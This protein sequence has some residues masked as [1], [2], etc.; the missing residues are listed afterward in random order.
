MSRNLVTSDTAP[1][2]K[3]STVWAEG[4]P[5]QVRA[6]AGHP[7]RR[8]LLRGTRLQ[9]VSFLVSV[10]LFSLPLIYIA[11]Q[12]VRPYTAFL[13]N[14]TG[15]PRSFTLA[16]I[17]AAWEQGGFA[18]QF[19]NGALFAGIPDIATLILGV[20][21]AFPISRAYVRFSGAL[22]ALFVFGPFLP[23][24]IIP[25]FI[26]AK[27]LHMYD[28][29]LGYILLVSL[30]G[31][32]GFFFFVGY[33]KGIPRELDEAAALDGCGY[34]RFIFRI[35]IPQMR[36]P[37]AT[38]GIVGFV[39]GWNNFIL[40]LVMLPDSGLWPVTRGL[41]SYFGEY[42]ESLPA[43]AAATLIV[44]VPIIVVY[45]IFQRNI[46]EGVSGGARGFGG[47]AATGVRAAASKA[48]QPS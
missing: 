7:W 46:L 42:T 35:L 19:L 44:A 9:V 37:L 47:T 30:N 15:I 1:Q 11:V 20:F 3:H 17:T 32:A 18:H 48:D 21:L 33:I 14:P 31:G 16:N 26:E 24:G 41:Y 23:V 34:I 25:L 43:V 2:T 13:Q 29:F 10:G 45:A 4:T 5:P 38:F 6:P 8:R 27:S 28:N 36:A 22:Y 40:P 39:F 12:A